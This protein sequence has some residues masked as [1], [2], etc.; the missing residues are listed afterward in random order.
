MFSFAMRRRV[1]PAVLHPR[2]LSTSGGGGSMGGGRNKSWM[3]EYPWVNLTV[4]FLLGYEVTIFIERY[5]L[6]PKQAALR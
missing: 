2:P 1:L 6:K 5:I 3:E 4:G